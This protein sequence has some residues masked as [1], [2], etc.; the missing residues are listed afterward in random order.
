MGCLTPFVIE[1]VDKISGLPSHVLVPCGHC[2]GCLRKKQSDWISRLLVETQMSL[3]SFFVT[4]TYDETH[5][6]FPEGVNKKDV[7]LFW[8]TFRKYN[9]FGKF[10]YFLVSEYGGITSRPHYHCLL[11]FR[12]RVDWILL[13]RLIEKTW[14]NGQH[15]IGT[16]D[17]ASISYCAKYCLKSRADPRRIYDNKTFSMMSK[18]PAIGYDLLVLSEKFAER[19]CFEVVS[20]DKVVSMP[21]YYRDKIHDD[22]AKYNHAQEIQEKYRKLP[23][24]LT[25]FDRYIYRMSFERKQ[26]RM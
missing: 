22:L 3:S 9:S 18:R 24:S 5:L 7:Q 17:A 8:K 16:V 19:E 10:K 26:R 23:S 14:K 15:K 2:E 20:G 12:S 21:R 6:P 25:A 11:F 1:V 4:L 13:S